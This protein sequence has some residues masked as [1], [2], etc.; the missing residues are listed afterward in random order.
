[1][2]ETITK[3]QLLEFGLLIGFGFPILIGWLLPSIFGHAFRAWTLGIGV[4][5]L[6]LGL[7][8]P[9]LLYYPY[10]SWMILGHVLGWINSHII[11][12]LVFILVLQPIAYIMRLTGYDP[13]KTKRKGEKTYREV[14]IDNNID[15]KRIF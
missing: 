15:L 4:P 3:K 13:L 12:G 10:K 2:K 8:A 9:R 5:V 11:L 6:I 1:M 7:T 14:R